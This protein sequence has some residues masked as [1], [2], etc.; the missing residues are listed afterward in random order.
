MK[1]F[2]PKTINNPHGFTLI[3]LMVVITII[4]FLSVIGAVAFT[5]AQ[6]NARDGRR[7]ADVEAISTALEANFSS[8][9]YPAVTCGTEPVVIFSNGKCPKTP[10]NTGYIGFPTDGTI[11][12]AATYEVCA[13]LETSGTSKEV[14][15]TEEDFCRK[16]QQ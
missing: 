11:A 15:G 7:R 6:K 16:N 13:D 5:N 1:K 2:L 12:A 8:G 9:M 3:E 14:D 4:A 10:S